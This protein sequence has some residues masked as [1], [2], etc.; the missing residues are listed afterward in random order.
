MIDWLKDPGY[1]WVTLSARDGAERETGYLY[2]YGHLVN[3]EA[4]PTEVLATGDLRGL[5]RRRPEELGYRQRKQAS[6]SLSAVKSK[7]IGCTQ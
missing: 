2:I 7:R 1:R 4:P 6:V 5:H 3:I